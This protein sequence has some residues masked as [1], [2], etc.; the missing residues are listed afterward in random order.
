MPQADVPRP[1]SGLGG[2]L[3]DRFGGAREARAR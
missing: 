3:D 2:W 1:V